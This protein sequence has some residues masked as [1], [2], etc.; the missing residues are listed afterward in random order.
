MPWDS[1][2]DVQMTNT[3]VHFLASYYN[4][5]IHTYE[6]RNYLL[7][8][9]PK[10]TD[11]SYIDYLNVIDARWIDI[12]T[13][14]FIDITAVRPHPNRRN[15]LCS[16]DKH[17]ERVSIAYN[18]GTFLQHADPD[19]Y[20]QGQDLFPLRDSLFEGQRVKIPYAYAKLLTMEYGKASLTKTK[21]SG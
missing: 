9:N 17:E 3:T 21:Y 10:Y 5:T 8:V 1:D 15:V 4:M 20:Y 18:P 16:K 13:G 11:G 2:I 19:N 6:K 7:E 12:E 14:L